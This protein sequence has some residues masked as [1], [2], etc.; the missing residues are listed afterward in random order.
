MLLHFELHVPPKPPHRPNKNILA[1]LHIKHGLDIEHF[2]SLTLAPI[3]QGN[4]QRIVAAAVQRM[5]LPKIVAHSVPSC[6]RSIPSHQTPRR[7]YPDQPLTLTAASTVAVPSSGCS[8]TRS[9]GQVSGL[10]APG[11]Q[12]DQS[13]SLLTP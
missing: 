9:A 10:E 13:P 5:P 1:G 11:G 3:A 12:R 2:V 6:P 7:R 8:V 4:D